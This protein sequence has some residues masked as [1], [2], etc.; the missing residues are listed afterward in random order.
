MNYTL[1]LHKI[2]HRLFKYL[3]ILI[4]TVSSGIKKYP[5][6]ERVIK[7]TSRFFAFFLL[8]ITYWQLVM[9]L[10]RILFSIHILLLTILLHA[11]II[12]LSYIRIND[13]KLPKIRLGSLVNDP[14]HDYAVK[15]IGADFIWFMKRAYIYRPYVGYYCG[16][17]FPY[18]L[19]HC[20]S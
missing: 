3:Q 15:K 6:E 9:R 12:N 18:S 17:P 14:L 1:H 10:A 7:Y 19:I 20:V 11:G 4:N 16:T 8:P 2:T 5:Q 13:R